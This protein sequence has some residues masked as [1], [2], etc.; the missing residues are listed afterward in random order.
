MNFEI[1]GGVQVQVIIGKALFLAL[2][3]G[4]EAERPKPSPVRPVLY[5]R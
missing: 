1:P 5:G 3:N 4:A 2:P